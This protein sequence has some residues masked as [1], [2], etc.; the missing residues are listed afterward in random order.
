MSSGKTKLENWLAVGWRVALQ[1]ARS[2]WRRMSDLKCR[3]CRGPKFG[4]CGNIYR[5]LSPSR[6]PSTKYSA[7]SSPFESMLM[8]AAATTLNP[9]H[10]GD[11]LLSA[12]RSKRSPVLVGL[13][14][15]VDSLPSGLVAGEGRE[16]R[17]SGFASFCRGVIDVVAPLVPAV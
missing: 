9:D 17:A 3:C 13:D 6:V 2:S 7:L 1:A 4:M 5:R 10:F 8:P 12:V 15:R 16:A 14:P 11:R